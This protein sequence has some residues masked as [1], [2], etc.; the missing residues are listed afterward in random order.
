M[1]GQQLCLQVV[2]DDPLGGF[3]LTRAAT[4][5]RLRL[6]QPES[7]GCCPGLLQQ[8]PFADL[9]CRGILLP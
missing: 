9:G 4:L 7:R 3:S 1:V 8:M 5:M 2:R 6:L